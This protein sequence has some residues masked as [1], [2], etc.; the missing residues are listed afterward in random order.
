MPFSVWNTS[1]PQRSASENVGAPAGTI[2]NSCMSTL[3]SACAPPLMMF[4]IGTGS[5]GRVLEPMCAYRSAF[6]R[7][8]AALARRARRRGSRSRPARLS[9]RAV[10]LDQALVER[11]LIVDARPTSAWRISPSTFATPW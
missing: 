1:T 7:R 5:R 9:G 11:R 3:L 2:M 8:A 4:I 6:G 10:E